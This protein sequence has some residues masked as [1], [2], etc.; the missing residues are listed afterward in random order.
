MSSISAS[1]KKLQKK[2][3]NFQEKLGELMKLDVDSISNVSS[4]ST[5]DSTTDCSLDLDQ[6]H[7]ETTPKEVYDYSK[8]IVFRAFLTVKFCLR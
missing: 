8:D 2:R 1:L 7:D 5:L 4:L 3:E 6:T